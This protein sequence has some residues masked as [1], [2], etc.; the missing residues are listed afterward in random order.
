M[1][2][3]TEDEIVADMQAAMA[4]LKTGSRD[5]RTIQFDAGR[6]EEANVAMKAQGKLIVLH[7]ELTEMLFSYRPELADDTVAAGGG[8]R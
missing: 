6:M 2:D 4:V 5:M 1:V 7:A 3:R 8:N